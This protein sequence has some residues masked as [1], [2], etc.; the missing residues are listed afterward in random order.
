MELLDKGKHCNEELCRQLD[1]LPIQ[2]KAC[3]KYFCNEHFS[4]EAHNCK[5]AEKFDYKI[6]TCE[7]CNQT[8]EFKRGKHLDLCLAEHMQKCQLEIKPTNKEKTSK[9]CHFKNCKSKEVFVFK[10]DDC[11]L[12]Y[13]TKHRLAEDH[14]CKQTC[15]VQSRNKSSKTQS[16]NFSIFAY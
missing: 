6:P 13:C 9:K 12:N 3:L 10:C 2:C 8:I 11:C 5:S 1:Y 4:Y 7:L 14:L 15:S 16:R